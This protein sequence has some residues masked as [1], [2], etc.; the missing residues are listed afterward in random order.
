MLY[1]IQ[2]Y[3][4]LICDLQTGGLGYDVPAGRRDGRVSLIAETRALPPSTANLNQLTQMFSTHGLTQEDMVTLSGT[5]S[6]EWTM[7]DFN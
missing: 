7:F 1:V 4:I 6:F 5:R 2:K 3:L